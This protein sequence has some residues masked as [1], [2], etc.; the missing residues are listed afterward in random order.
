MGEVMVVEVEALG[1]SG[2]GEESWFEGE[3]RRRGRGGFGFRSEDWSG[4]WIQC[5]TQV[6]GACEVGGGERA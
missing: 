1:W 3:G 6:L 4:G 2:C 5:L